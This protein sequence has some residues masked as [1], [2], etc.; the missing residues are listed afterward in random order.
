[1]RSGAL[2][3]GE[4]LRGRLGAVLGAAKAKA[5]SPTKPNLFT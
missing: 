4:D 3:S 5:K 2:V 1:M